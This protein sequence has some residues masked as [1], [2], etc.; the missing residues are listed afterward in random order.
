MARFLLFT[1][2]MLLTVSGA[3]EG[4]RWNAENNFG[5]WGKPVRLN[6]E[7]KDGLLQFKSTGRD[8]FF[9]LDQKLD[10]KDCKYFEIVYRTAGKL[11]KENETV[12][13]F[14]TGEDKNFTEKHIINLGRVND[15]GEWQTNRVRLGEKT[16]CGWEDWQKADLIKALRMDLI[17]G[18]GE[19]EIRSMSFLTEA[20]EVSGGLLE[21]VNN[22]YFAAFS[23]KYELSTENPAEGKFCMVQGDDSD[24]E[25]IAVLTGV[26]PVKPDTRY[27]LKVAARNDI[28]LGHVIFGF[29]QSRSADKF[30]ITNSSEWGWTQLACNMPEWKDCVMNF[31][32]FPTTRGLRIYFKVRNNGTGKAW[33][34][35]LELVEVKDETPEIAMKPFLLRSSF[36]DIPTMVGRR[37]ESG[38]MEWVELKPEDT[39][40]QLECNSFVPGNAI[41][42]LTVSRAGKKV[43][44]QARKASGKLDFILPL[45]EWPAGKYQ[46]YAAAELDGKTLCSMEKFLWRQQSVPERKLA[47]V[48]DISTLPD[49]LLAINGKP[50]FSVYYGGFPAMHIRPDFTEY[51]NAV[52][53][54]KTA[55]QQLCLTTLSVVSYSKDAP[56]LQ[57][58]R[59]EY[60]PKA[61][62]FYTE[63]YLKQ[64][65]FC[66]ANNLYGSAS[67]HMGSSL[68]PSGLVDYELIRGVARNIRHHPALIGYGY[69]EP[70]ARK[71]APEMIV[72]M[73]QTVKAEDPVHPVCV[74]LCQK[75]TFKQYLEGSDVASFDNYP[76]PYSDLNSWRE[77]LQAV[78]AAK[79]GVPFQTY[80]QSFQYPDAAV[81]RNEDIY[82]EFILSLIAGSRSVLFFSWN[83]HAESRCHCLVSDPEMQAAARLVSEQG[84]RLSEFLYEAKPVPVSLKA[85]PNIVYQFYQGKEYGLLLAVN[86]SGIESSPIQLSFSGKN[87]SD[88]MDPAWTWKENETVILKP[89]QTLT[90]RISDEKQ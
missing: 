79:D 6:L 12:I 36:T 86:L 69:D 13:Y 33:W 20:E 15:N 52:E 66:Q 57:L 44:E 76:F 56:S 54:L 65:D 26:I 29:G 71:V 63:Q 43:F 21:E 48:R 34:D 72:Q 55:R 46:L 19:M 88:A 28:P 3:A 84:C 75:T 78:L 41:V 59:E 5:D 11:P 7:R 67:L 31:T 22:G 89:N 64:L 4:I 82:A 18:P 90:V 62:A 42:R 83:E 39:P 25:S 16:V 49:R 30:K 10:L 23:G 14:Q 87:L 1:L 35:K 60:L 2:V 27:Q 47:P 24:K 53:I 74:N 61:I 70:D 9:Q 51:P 17:N 45:R 68:R 37:A 77:Y 40:L 50:F 85:S 8:P 32:T 73:Y 38:N 58:P 81:P 80:L